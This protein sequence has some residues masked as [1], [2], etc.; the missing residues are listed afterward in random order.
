MK[1]KISAF[2]SYQFFIDGTYNTIYSQ[3]K[4]VGYAL[5]LLFFIR[6]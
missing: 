3:F 2:W 5:L 6:I 4:A 1:R